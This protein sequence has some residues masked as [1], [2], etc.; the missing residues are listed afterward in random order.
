MPQLAPPTGSALAQALSETEG[1]DNESMIDI[2]QVEGRVR[3]SS[4]RKIGEI[5][6]KHPSE[7][8]SIL[9]GWIYQ[10]S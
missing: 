2:T 5:V 7:A 9:R 3:A 10:E 8:V 4:L 1:D 6:E